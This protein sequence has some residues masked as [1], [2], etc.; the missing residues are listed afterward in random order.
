MPSGNIVT[1]LSF[2][3][4]SKQRKKLRERLRQSQKKKRKNNS[5]PVVGSCTESSA[6]GRPSAAVPLQDLK[7]V[8]VS[9]RFY[10]KS[11]RTYICRINSHP[12]SAYFQ[13]CNGS[14]RQLVTEET[15]TTFPTSKYATANQPTTLTNISSQR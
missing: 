8:N 12:G 7:I 10:I 15:E 13:P 2:S 11:M 3:P 5:N 4:T 1:L 6:A 9:C 14:M